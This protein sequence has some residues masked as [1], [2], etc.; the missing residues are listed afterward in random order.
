MSDHFINAIFQPVNVPRGLIYADIYIRGPH[1]SQLCLIFIK[2][3]QFPSEAFYFL[4][5]LYTDE[6]SPTGYSQ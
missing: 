4:G 5:N 2:K 6:R 3:Y 1:N